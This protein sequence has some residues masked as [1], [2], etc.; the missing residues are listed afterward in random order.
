MGEVVGDALRCSG[1]GEIRT[2]SL[3]TRISRVGYN[4]GAPI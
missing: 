2:C 3:C 1:W 4:L